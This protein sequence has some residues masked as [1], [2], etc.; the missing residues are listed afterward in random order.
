MEKCGAIGKEVKGSRKPE[1]EIDF[2]PDARH[3]GEGKEKE[4]FPKVV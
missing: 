3:F 1:N 2:I 4:T